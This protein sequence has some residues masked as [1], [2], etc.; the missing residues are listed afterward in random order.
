MARRT[1]SGPKPEDSPQP[2]RGPG[3]PEKPINLK[4]L[5]LLCQ[6][7]CTDAE[8]AAFFSVSTK[9]IERRK[10]NPEFLETMERGQLQGLV[11]LR[12]AQFKNA[13]AGNTTMQIWLGK[14][15]LRQRDRP[16]EEEKQEQEPVTAVEYRWVMPEAKEEQPAP[17]PEPNLKRLRIAA[18]QSPKPESSDFHVAYIEVLNRK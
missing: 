8:I 17:E 1:K 5:A 12:Q 9:T 11:S 14:Q 7:Q 3:Q 15:L 10:A 18:R 4:Q 2:K 6:M 16:V 13:L